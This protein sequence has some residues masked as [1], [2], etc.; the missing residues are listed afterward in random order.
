MIPIIMTLALLSFDVQAKGK[1]YNA[2]KDY[3][4]QQKINRGDKIP[5]RMVTCRLKKR[6]KAKN[7]DEVCIYQGQNKTYELSIE[8]NCPRQYRC[9]YKPWGQEPNIYSVI[10][11]LNESVK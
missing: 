11:S 7:G 4:N 9:E 5:P 8:K 6:I 10:D 1:I 2:P 3:T